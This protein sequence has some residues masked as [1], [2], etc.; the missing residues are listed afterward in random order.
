M[1]N[2]VG[3]R[4]QTRKIKAWLRIPQKAQ[5]MNGNTRQTRRFVGI[6]NRVPAEF[7]S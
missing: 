7:A 5:N 2:P 6:S 3:K 4:F 1:K